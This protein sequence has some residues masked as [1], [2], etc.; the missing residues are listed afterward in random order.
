MP[1]KC[2]CLRSRWTTIGFVPLFVFLLQLIIISNTTF[3]TINFWFIRK[4]N[5]NSFFVR[6]AYSPCLIE[7]LH[8][9]RFLAAMWKWVRCLETIAV[10]CGNND[11]LPIFIGRWMKNHFSIDMFVQWTRISWTF[12]ID[13]D[14]LAVSRFFSWPTTLIER[15]IV[16]GEWAKDDFS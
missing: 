5:V 9:M 16:K 8:F 3:T 2:I 15:T 14:R 13:I 1:I 12:E 10:E 4:V 6:C 7:K 11:V